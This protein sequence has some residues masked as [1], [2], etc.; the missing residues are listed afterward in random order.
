MITGNFEFTQ[1]L[2]LLTV[3][4]NIGGGKMHQLALPSV[5]GDL[6]PQPILSLQVGTY[7]QD[8]AKGEIF[9]GAK[10]DYVL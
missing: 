7:S 1:Q 3:Q 10:S 6:H 9:Q 2:I 8:N 4:L 5:T